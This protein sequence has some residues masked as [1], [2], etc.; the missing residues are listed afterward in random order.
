MLRTIL[1]FTLLTGLLIALPVSSWAA[2]IA[3]AQFTSDV[4]EREPI[5]SLG[6]IIP[7]QYGGIQKVYFYTDLRDMSG[8]QVLHR[9]TLD[10]DIM[11]EIPFNIGG[12]R[13]RVWSSKRLLPGFDGTWTVE[14]VQNGTVIDSHSFS[15]LDE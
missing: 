1:K 15:Y 5:D 8:D 9:W 13:W 4:I 7:V 11:A 6:P 3:R 2:S 12:D 14:I 10:G